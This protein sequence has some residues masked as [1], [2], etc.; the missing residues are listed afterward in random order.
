MSQSA[1]AGSPGRASAKTRWVKKWRSLTWY[2]KALSLLGLG[3]VLGALALLVLIA[4]V[5]A[6]A[7]GELPTKAQI[8]AIQ[9][10]SASTLYDRN[11]LLLSR[12]Y[13]ENREAIHYEDLP[14][15]LIEAL[16]ATEDARFFEHEGIDWIATARAVV[17][18]GLLGQREQGGGSTLS[19][20][21]AKRHFSRRGGGLPRLVLAKITEAIIA[22]RFEEVYDKEEL[23]GLYFN[24]V[25]FGE[26]IYGVK[27][28]ARRYFNVEPDQ[29][30]IEQAAVLVG[31]LKGTTSY[32]PVANPERAIE[33][34][35]LV[36]RRMRDQGFITVTDY[37]ELSAMPLGLEESRA[38]AQAQTS[39][40]SER[41][42]VEV[43]A[44]LRALE[45]QNAAAP[46][47]LFTSGL[48]ITTTIDRELQTIAE[49]SL[50][51]TLA[52][53]QPKFREQYARRDPDQFGPLLEAAVQAS[54]RYRAMKSQGMSP[55]E[56][57][58]SFGESRTMRFAEGAALGPG[59]RT[60][61]Y[62]DSVRA[63]LLRLRAGIMVADPYTEEVLAY[64][65]GEDYA[66]VPFNSASAKR[67]VGSTFKPIVYAAALEHGVAPC[68]Y[69][70]N[71]LRTYADYKDWTPENADGEY[72][73]EY[74]LIGG[75]VGSVNTVAVQLVFEA[76]IARAKS[77]AAAMGLMDVPAEPSIALGTASLS[78]EEMTR[79]YGVF[80]R[81]GLLPTY[82]YVLRIE[83]SEGEVLYERNEPVED[84]RVLSRHT[85]EVMDFALR[86]AARRGTGAG[87]YSRFG[88]ESEV[89]GKTGTTQDQAD[90][91][92]MGYTRDL[93]VGAWVGGQ[94]P[95]IRWRSL[96]QGQGARTALP[97]V[98][99]FIRGYEVKRGVTKLPPLPED[100]LLDVTCE[101]YIDE[102]ELNPF[103]E[104]RDFASIMEAIR[105]RRRQR[106]AQRGTGREPRVGV[107]ER[108]RQRRRA[109]EAQ[110]RAREEQ[111][112][113]RER[114]AQQRDRERRREARRERRRRA[115]EKIF[116]KPGG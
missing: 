85:G 61:S 12:Y 92:F 41:L 78:L 57:E 111:R 105:E 103:E 39:Y 33:R 113:D 94:Y 17:Y 89:A 65:G 38:K 69:F 18:S 6:G 3:I 7:F 116:K 86:Q 79:A 26:N 53:L 46:Y 5:S 62:R 29:L 50:Q 76:G 82:G 10:H 112:R 9:T 104:D 87:L 55:A 25:D 90:G 52:D 59:E 49:R 36:L 48:H 14:P 91:W 22:G 11:G 102:V 54:D 95:T 70:P 58:T 107:D 84:T 16:V 115:L 63:E 110:R 74:S 4:A 109:A 81:R 101:D 51:T 66:T 24:S 1:R 43:D 8:A 96:S 83:D 27:V 97:I 47:D 23:I 21:L 100:V 71:E 19:Q 13:R 88:I 108:N 60:S 44:I 73:G 68:Q 106:E 28:A 45:E 30:R 35:N 20:Q 75:L 72:G 40:V 64:V 2:Y 80:A 99:R 42:R 114:A 34:R 37:A 56:I 31:M 67:Q 77:L 32:N 98:G 15:V 93:V